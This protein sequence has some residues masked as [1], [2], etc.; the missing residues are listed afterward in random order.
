MIEP[1]LPVTTRDGTI[2]RV[3][4]HRPPGDGPFPT[5]VCTHPY[6]K[7]KVP[8]RTRRGGY[9]VSFQ[10]RVLRQTDPIRFSNLTTWEAP[11]PAWWT[12]KGYALVNC[13]LR[14]AGT[15]DGVG[16][17]LSAQE[18]EDISDLVEWAA[19]QSWSTGAVALVGVSYLALSQW[20][21]ASKRPPSLRAI[22]PWEGFSVRI[23]GSSRHQSPPSA[24]GCAGGGF[25]GLGAG[26]MK[27]PRQSYS[28][29]DACLD[30][31]L[32]D[33]WWRALTP[34]L[35]K[36]EVP[37]LI[38]G[39]FSDNNLH[40]RGSIDG[41][42]RI[43]SPERHLHTHRAGKRAPFY[44]DEAKAV[45]LQF[46]DRHLRGL[47]V[48]ALPNV[49]LEVREAADQVVEVR[50]EATWPLERTVWTPLHLSAAGLTEAAADADGSLRF[51]IRNGGARF[52]WTVPDDVELT[53]PMTLRLHVSVDGTDDVDLV[54]GVE[55]WRDGR[56]VG[57]EGS[58]GFGRDRVATGWLSASLRDLDPDRS[59]PF[60][61][62]PTF[63]ERRPLGDGEVV[64]LDIALGPSSTLFR[65]GDQLRLVVAG[66]WLWPVNPLTGQFPARYRTSKRCSCTLHWGPDHDAHLLLPVIPRN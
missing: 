62:V 21:G 35:S 58:Y 33:D 18:G 17:L 48:P 63:T 52:G 16:Q 65:R 66:R 57:F 30:R 54:V 19:A 42:E 25:L 24:G 15:S 50:D 22:I 53:G 7:D 44:S 28:L 40:S 14:G 59:R 2:L 31:P 46:L 55:K 6:G 64:P 11:D 43:R 51:V 13:D 61:S 4:V 49:R 37:A 26:G 27:S 56:Y 29:M 3:N 23:S 5:I 34:D 60:Q 45:Q 20:N 9:R 36:I 38:C 10:Y 8:V 41:F 1:D 12:G 39:S 32:M 47:D